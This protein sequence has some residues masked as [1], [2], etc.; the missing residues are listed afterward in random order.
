MVEL[1]AILEGEV[2]NLPEKYTVSNHL[3]TAILEVA[4][5]MQD[6][7]DDLNTI[8]MFIKFSVLQCA[9]SWD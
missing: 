3:Q 2:A 7:G 4:Q 9:K 1:K 6:I 8:G 5:S